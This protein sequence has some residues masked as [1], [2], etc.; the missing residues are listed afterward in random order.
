MQ[1]SL[2]QRAYDRFIGCETDYERFNHI[3][4]MLAALN[5]N[6]LAL[7]RRLQQLEDNNSSDD[8]VTARPPQPSIAPR[9]E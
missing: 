4:S 8:R 1:N 5:A 9:G 2:Y 3:S 7:E 6:I